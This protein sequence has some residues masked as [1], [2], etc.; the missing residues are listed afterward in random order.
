MPDV[1]RIRNLRG[2]AVI[3]QVMSSS[4]RRRAGR[5]VVAPE[6]PPSA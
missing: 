1:T 4:S 5:S 2:A 3:A 6:N